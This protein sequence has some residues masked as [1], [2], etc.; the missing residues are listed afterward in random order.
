METTAK[1]FN[2]ITWFIQ[3][4]KEAREEMTKV[5]W[6]SKQETTRYALVVVVLSLAIAVFFGGLD[7][8]LTK[9]LELLVSLTSA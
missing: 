8:L 9:G 2:P 6:P 4:V 7:W 5:T 3:Y 1:K